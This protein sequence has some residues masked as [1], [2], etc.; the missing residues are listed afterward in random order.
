MSLP[1]LLDERGQ[2]VMISRRAAADA[3]RTF[4]YTG[5]PCK[6]GHVSLRYVTSGGCAACM[7]TN[8]KPRLN[9]WTSK[10]VPFTNPHLW[11]LASFS[12]TQRL[13]LR[14]YVQHCIFEFIRAQSKELDLNAR[15][16]IE[17]AMLEIEERNARL[18][19]EDPRYTD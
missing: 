16:E 19:I 1:A 17:A 15:A 4:F 3:G 12:K 7:K 5:A 6:H 2:P 13:A 8:Y 18:T 14:V 11:T 10:L 9:P